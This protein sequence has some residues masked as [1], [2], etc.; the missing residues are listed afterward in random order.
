MKK[1]S[2]KGL[3][4]GCTSIGRNFCPLCCRIKKG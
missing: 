1:S 2:C 4:Y 3:E